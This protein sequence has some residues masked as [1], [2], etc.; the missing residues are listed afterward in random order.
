THATASAHAASQPKNFIRRF[1]SG[2]VARI[3][4]Q[5]LAPVGVESSARARRLE[6]GADL[7]LQPLRAIAFPLAQRDRQAELQ[8]S[9]RRQPGQAQAGGVSQVAQADRFAPGE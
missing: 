1:L 4:A 9:D 3:V 6:T 5:R 8:R 2:W 7:E